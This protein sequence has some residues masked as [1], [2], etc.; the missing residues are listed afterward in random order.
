[1]KYKKKLT[2]TA[3]ALA[4]LIAVSFAMSGLSGSLESQNMA[5]RWQAGSLKYAQ[6]SVF[7]PQTKLA[8]SVSLTLSAC[9]P[10]IP[11]CFAVHLCDLL[12]LQSIAS[13]FT[14]VSLQVQ[15][16]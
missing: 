11:I 6:V 4:A 10:E 14:S 13:H 15:P 9:P 1:M 3:I 8:H 7:Y 2:G 16:S 12:N 5:E